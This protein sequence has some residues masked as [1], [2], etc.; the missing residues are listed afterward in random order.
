MD[1]KIIVWSCCQCFSSFWTTLKLFR[2][3]G[4]S[5]VEPR[6]IKQIFLISSPFRSAVTDV[7]DMTVDARLITY[8]HFNLNSLVPKMVFCVFIKSPF[9]LL[10]FISFDLSH[11]YLLLLQLEP[12]FP[13]GTTTTNLVHWYFS[14]ASSLII[15]TNCSEL[16]YRVS[17][18]SLPEAWGFTD[19]VC[20]CVRVLIGPS[21]Y[22]SFLFVV[23]ALEGKAT[24]QMHY[25]DYFQSAQYSG[26]SLRSIG[27]F[28]VNSWWRWSAGFRATSADS[29]TAGSRPYSCV[30]EQDN[31]PSEMTYE[32]YTHIVNSEAKTTIHLQS[33]CKNGSVCACC[34]IYGLKL[35]GNIMRQEY[36]TRLTTGLQCLS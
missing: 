7:S 1:E 13:S 3:D 12:S 28:L 21:L 2:V 4:S 27:V 35:L 24:L 34:W 11:H 23:R 14:V 10:L 30:L 5:S 26:E 15:L 20:V 22:K 6:F 17:S 31:D 9:A 29:V 18:L 32:D 8:V 25:L 19:G 33:H 36:V 16:S